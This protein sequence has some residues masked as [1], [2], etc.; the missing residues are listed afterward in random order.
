MRRGDGSNAPYGKLLYVSP[1]STAPALVRLPGDVSQLRGALYAEGQ[2][3]EDRV[4]KLDA[5]GSL[6]IGPPS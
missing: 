3:R 2:T 4:S 1:P 6:S 5:W